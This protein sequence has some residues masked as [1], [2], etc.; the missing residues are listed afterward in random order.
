MDLSDGLVKDAERMLRG[1]GVAG[2]LRPADVP[3]S[4]PARKVLARQP[5]RLA[6]LITGGDDYEVLAA[7]PG[8]RAHRDELRT[9]AGVG[10][11]LTDIGTVGPSAWPEAGDGL[12]IE[13]VDGRPIALDRTGWDH[14]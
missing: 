1:S 14:F 10:V 11:S 9:A 13:G 4:D 5:E 2:R 8:P 6:Q 3:L 7:V 12:Q